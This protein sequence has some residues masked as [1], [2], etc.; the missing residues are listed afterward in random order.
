MKDVVL[1]IS[2]LGNADFR[3]RRQIL[4]ARLHE[5]QMRV[6]ERRARK[7]RVE[8]YRQVFGGLS[9]GIRRL[10]RSLGSLADRYSRWRQEQIA[11]REIEALDD[12][13]LRDI[14]IQRSDIRTV[15]QGL[16]AR[17]DRRR[18]VRDFDSAKRNAERREAGQALRKAA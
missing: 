8:A 1:E 9:R 11:T 18:S 16:A 17:G 2:G 3:H 6:I 10:S 4:D 15:V 13:L 7:A 12:R 14:G 5:K